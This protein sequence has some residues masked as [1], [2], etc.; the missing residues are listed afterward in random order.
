MPAAAE[1]RSCIGSDSNDC[2]QQQQGQ[3]ARI[4]DS[5][6]NSCNSCS[7]ACSCVLVLAGSDTAAHFL[8]HPWR[9]GAAHFRK[10]RVSKQYLFLNARAKSS[11]VIWRLPLVAVSLA[12]AACPFP[13]PSRQTAASACCLM[14]HPSS[15]CNTGGYIHTSAAFRQ[16]PSRSFAS[17]PS[18]QVLSV[19]CCFFPAP[20]TFRPAPTISV[21]YVCMSTNHCPAPLC[22]SRPQRCQHAEDGRVRRAEVPSDHRV[23]HEEDRGQQHPGER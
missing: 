2:W 19:H 5:S 18:L 21:L 11:A 20:V 15:F 16:F 3:P 22:L 13:L 14:V 7:G 17:T 4:G 6:S 10:M 9:A 12:P 23:C 8:A 1:G